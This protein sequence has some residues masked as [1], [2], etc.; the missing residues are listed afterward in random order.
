MPCQP[1][2]ALDRCAPVSCPTHPNHAI[3]PVDHPSILKPTAPLNCRPS[4]EQV[5]FRHPACKLGTSLAQRSASL[6]DAECRLLPDLRPALIDRLRPADEPTLLRLRPLW[7]AYG[8]PLPPAVDC[9]VEVRLSDDPDAP[10]YPY[11]PHCVLGKGGL[12]VV[13]DR[14]AS[15]AVQGVLAKLRG[16]RARLF[17]GMRL[18]WRGPTCGGVGVLSLSSHMRLTWRCC[19]RAPAC[20]FC[21]QTVCTSNVLLPLP[22]MHAHAQMTWPAPPSSFRV[23]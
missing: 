19:S 15:P 17:G 11:P 4:A 5:E 10:T 7:A 2:I 22:C 8:M 23:K 6:A 21:L 14:L 18:G 12:Q 13:A 3:F 16:G 9:L 20:N 1:S